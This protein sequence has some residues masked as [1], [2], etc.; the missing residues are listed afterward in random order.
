MATWEKEDVVF[1]LVNSTTGSPD[2]TSHTVKLQPIDQAYDSGA[3]A[4]SQKTVVTSMWGPDSDLDDLKHYHIYV[5]D[6]KK[7]LLISRESVP[8]IGG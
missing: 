7:D 6:D 2:T 5:D 3:I 8:A 4:C 1:E